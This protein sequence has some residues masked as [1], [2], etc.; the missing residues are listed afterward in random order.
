MFV[1]GILEQILKALNLILT[2][3]FVHCDFK[4]ENILVLGGG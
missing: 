1:K 2:R 3:G 4:P